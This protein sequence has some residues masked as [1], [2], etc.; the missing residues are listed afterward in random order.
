MA[1]PS[2]TNALACSQEDDYKEVTVIL[3]PEHGD[4]SEHNKYTL[5]GRVLAE[6]ILNRG[7]VKA[8]ISKAWGNPEGLKI[9]DQ[10]PNLYLFVFTKEEEMQ[11]IMQKQ[12]WFILN[13][14]LSLQILTHDILITEVEFSKVPF[15]VQL[16]GLPLGV[17]TEQNAFTIASQIG[18]PLEVEDSKIEGCMLRSFIRVRVMVN[19]LK[20]LLTGC[21]IPRENLPRIWVVFKYEK[22]QG[23]CYNCG[24]IGHEQ[25]NCKRSKVMSVLCKEIPR[26]GPRLG[27]LLRNLSLF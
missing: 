1:G 8:I 21:W 19:V 22:L 18:E 16:H 5:V 27:C 17:M 25:H 2:K 15:W 6:K 4:N 12:P 7:A 3:E 24:I 23:F 26:Y 10:G 14:M 20:P 11:E 9:S 13:H